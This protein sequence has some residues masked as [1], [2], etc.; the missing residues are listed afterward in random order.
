MM[1][2]SNMTG[3]KMLPKRA[4]EDEKFEQAVAFRRR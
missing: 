3:R 2:M 4:L 1:A